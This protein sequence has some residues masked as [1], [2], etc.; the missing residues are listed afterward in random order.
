MTEYDSK[1]KRQDQKAARHEKME[2]RGRA[3]PA[4]HATHGEKAKDA[5]HAARIYRS[6]KR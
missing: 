1:A 2:R 6:I 5:K 4:P 3:D